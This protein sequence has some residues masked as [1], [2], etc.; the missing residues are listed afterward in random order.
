[1]KSSLDRVLECA[2][3]RLEV[4][5][6]ELTQSRSGDIQGYSLGDGTWDR[7]FTITK[8]S[9]S[10]KYV[11]EAESYQHID[12]G[13]RGALPSPVFPYKVEY[14]CVQF[15]HP[16]QSIPGIFPSPRSWTAAEHQPAVRALLAAPQPALLTCNLN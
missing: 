16:Q 11:R 2:G 14:P 10:R 13:E 9:E 15:S 5:G 3:D 12:C 1:M 8:P 4:A 7:T 6:M